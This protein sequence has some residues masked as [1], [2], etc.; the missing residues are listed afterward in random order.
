MRTISIPTTQNIELEY[1]IATPGDRTTAFLIDRLIQGGYLFALNYFLSNSGIEPSTGTW[2]LLTLPATLYS[3]ITEV[4]F[5]GQTIGKKL[6]KMRVIRQDGSAPAF[7]DYFL[8]WVFGVLDTGISMGLLAFITTSM[9][10]KGQRLGDMVAGTTVVK[11]ELVT[12][13]DDTI[14]RDL[15]ESYVPTFTEVQLLSDKDL[16]ILQEVL[17]AGN[18]ANNPEIIDRL[19]RKI[20]EVTGVKSNLNNYHFLE[21]VLKDYN[22]LYGKG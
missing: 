15:D 17:A 18:R 4:A 12:H 19:A 10:K 20:K 14:F 2:I 8:R 5:G 16:A 22:Y 21:L 11:L 13:F 9:N 6:R 7:T 1:P 3:L